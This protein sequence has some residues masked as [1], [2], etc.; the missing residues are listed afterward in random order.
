MD[1]IGVRRLEENAKIKS[2]VNV[3]FD[4]VVLI[5]AVV[6]EKSFFAI[7]CTILSSEM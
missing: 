2:I 6:S 5:V 3:L 4:T 1:I 7:D